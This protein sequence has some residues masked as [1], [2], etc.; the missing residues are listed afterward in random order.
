MSY[1]NEGKEHTKGGDMQNGHNNGAI[2][3]LEAEMNEVWDTLPPAVTEKLAQPLE[4]ELVSERRGRGGRSFS[5]IE[6]H[7]AIRQANR[8]F[9]YGGWG[10]SLAGGV[11]LREFESVDASTGEVRLFRAYTAPVRVDVPGAPP[12]TDVGF[13]IVAD[14]SAEGH[15]TAFKGAVT[16]GLKRALRSFGDQFG[17]S[18]YGD[19]HTER[20]TERNG[21]RN[22]Q[23]Q[24]TEGGGRQQSGSAVCECGRTKSLDYPLCRDCHYGRNGNTQRSGGGRQ[25]R[26]GNRSKDSG[27]NGGSRVRQPQRN[28]GADETDPV[29]QAIGRLLE[30]GRSKGWSE[31]VIRERV[32][33]Q[34]GGSLESVGLDTLTALIR[35]I[36]G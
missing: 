21:G 33:Q 4:A 13:G 8:V 31:A 20:K 17:N 19:G 7:L 2:N 5:Y 34:Y 1:R 24:R 36:Q 14:D 27:G 26:S 29:A 32:Q 11:E 25:S 10:Y 15:E 22:A 30:V 23:G 3:G 18:L 12:R 9:G 16:D 35:R 6:G 28:S